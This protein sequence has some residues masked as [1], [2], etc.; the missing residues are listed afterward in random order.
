MKT[1]IKFCAITLTLVSGLAAAQQAPNPAVAA[2]RQACTSDIQKM[3]S[4]KQ[5][6]AVFAC[7]RQNND[8]LSADCKAAMAK[9]PARRPNPPQQ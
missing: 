1:Y 7:L 6:R 4:D 3:C 2:A 5:G 8:N 9:L